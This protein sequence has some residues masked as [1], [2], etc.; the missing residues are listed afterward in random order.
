MARISKLA[1]RELRAFWNLLDKRDLVAARKELEEFFPSLVQAYGDAAATISADWFEELTG[2]AA[3]LGDDVNEERANAKM[4]WAIGAGFDGDLTQAISTLE[5]VADEL[6][7]QFGRD[8]IVNSATG[9][10][11]R[12]ARVPVGETCNWCIMMGSRGFVYSSFAAA[13][14]LSRWHGGDCD[15]QV[16]PEDGTIPKGYDPDEL[17]EKY[18][19]ARETEPQDLLNRDGMTEA[20]YEKRLKYLTGDDDNAIAARMRAMYGGD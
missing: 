7:K 16:I 18:E 5:M 2:D 3:F 14:G 8:T 20:E 19:K 4:R 6:V 17:Y 1:R 10:G 11:R 12:F 15:C 13:G 9:N